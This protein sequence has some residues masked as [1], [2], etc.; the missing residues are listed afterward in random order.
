MQLKDCK[1]FISLAK[2]YK[3]RFTLRDSFPIKTNN[4]PIISQQDMIEEV[5]KAGVSDETHITC[6]FAIVEKVAI[7]HQHGLPLI[8][9]DQLNIIA[10]HVS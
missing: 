3:W 8:Y 10:R 4:S 6:T 5:K 7:H 2:V 9:N 1:L